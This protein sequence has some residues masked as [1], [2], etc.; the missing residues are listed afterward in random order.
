M[1][2]PCVHRNT[3][4][5]LPSPAPWFAIQDTLKVERT[6][7]HR[8]PF[9]APIAV[10]SENPIDAAAF[11]QIESLDPRGVQGLVRK[12]ISVYLSDAPTLLG[13]I[14][15]A[16]A[17]SAPRDLWQAAHALKSSSASLG[18]LRL[19]SLCHEIETVGRA[20]GC[21][22]AADHLASIRLEFEAVRADLQSRL[23]VLPVQP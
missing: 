9:A 3:R 12:V 8:F 7:P 23:A 2:I 13:R 4:H 16:I 19:A 15:K 11:S 5:R 1:L 10:T 14:E 22:G 21:A 18:A 17:A 6:I 20:G